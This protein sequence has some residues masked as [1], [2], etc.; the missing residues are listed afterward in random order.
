MNDGMTPDPPAVF[1]AW[2]D[3]QQDGRLRPDQSARIATSDSASR[4]RAFGTSLVPGL[5][6]APGWAMALAEPSV[7]LGPTGGPVDGRAA[8]E[9]RLARQHILTDSSRDIH[10]LMT[11]APLRRRKPPQVLA[12]QIE[13]LMRATESATF[14]FGV[15]PDFADTTAD[16]TA[17]FFIYD[18]PG[19]VLVEIGT[20]AGEVRS[21]HREHVELCR[22]VFDAFAATA[23][24]GKDARELLSAVAEH[25]AKANTQHRPGL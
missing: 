23:C 17:D 12:E 1:T 15:V 2:R 18:L 3:L 8:A 24:Y 19:G 21:T 14:R 11:L 22:R 9:Q 25:A 16:P 4:I 20:V 5:V 7:A 13:H 6:Q 10:I